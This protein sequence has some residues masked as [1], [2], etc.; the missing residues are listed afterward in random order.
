VAC[1]ASNAIESMKLKWQNPTHFTRL[2]D[3]AFYAI[4]STGKKNR[5]EISAR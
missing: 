3:Q 2:K 4:T 1:T 5:A